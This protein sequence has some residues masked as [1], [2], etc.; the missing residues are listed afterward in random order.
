MIDLDGRHVTRPGTGGK[1]YAR[2]VQHAARPVHALNF[3]AMGIQQHG[4]AADQVDLIA[5]ELRLQ[6][7]I[8]G[9]YDRVDT[10]Q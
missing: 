6:I 5:R 9:D 2:R 4:A 1:Q 10:L 8:L 3:D 7:A